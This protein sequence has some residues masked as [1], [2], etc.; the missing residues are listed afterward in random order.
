MKDSKERLILDKRSDILDEI[1]RKNQSS[2]KILDK[3]R[4]ERE[5]RL[6]KMNKTMQSENDIKKKMHNHF[7]NQEKERIIIEK[8]IEKK[9]N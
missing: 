8:D 6:T 9:S 4:M 3:S 5:S 7:E 1:R 2:T